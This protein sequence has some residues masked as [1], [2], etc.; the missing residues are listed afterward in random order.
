MNSVVEML[1]SSVDNTGMKELY[2]VIV[3]RLGFEQPWDVSTIS[4]PNV[5]A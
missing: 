2:V 4:S 5:H 3:S 1:A